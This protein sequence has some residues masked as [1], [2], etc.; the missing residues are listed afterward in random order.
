M[1]ARLLILLTLV[2]TGPG[3]L[4]AQPISFFAV[5]N[6]YA[7]AEGPGSSNSLIRNAGNPRTVQ[8]I[9]NQ[10]Q[11]TSMV[12]HSITGI[13]Y[14]LTN[15]L[16]NGYP[17][18]Q[19]T[20]SDYQIQLGP[21]VAP[22]SAVAQFAS[23]FTSPP[24]TVRT[25]PLTVAPF[26]WLVGSPPVPSPWGV[27]IQFNTPYVYTGGNLALMVT[28]PGSDNPDQGNSLLDAAGTSSPGNGVDYTAITGNAYQALEGTQNLFTNVIRFTGVAAVPEPAAVSLVLLILAAILVRRSFIRDAAGTTP[29]EPP[30]EPSA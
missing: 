27:E 21:S 9:L 25:G 11:L 18:F 15:S 29:P 6:I 8:I 13:T 19:T 10:N 16:P 7:N 22:G 20:W 14:R 1:P 12:N 3:Y 5:P 4:I 26:S 28:H 2:L 17:I 23:N 30:P 24:V